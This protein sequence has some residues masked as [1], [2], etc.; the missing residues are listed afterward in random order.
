MPKYS[1]KPITITE[2]EYHEYEDS[3]TGCCLNCRER[4]HDSCE[5]DARAYECPECGK[6]ACY[7][8]GELLIMGLL[9]IEPGKE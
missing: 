1:R 6:T 3:M 7:G 5:P 4:T 9:T 2:S 8:A